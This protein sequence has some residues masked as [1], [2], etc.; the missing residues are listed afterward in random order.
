MEASYHPPNERE[1]IPSRRSLQPV[2]HGEIRSSGDVAVLPFRH[3]PPPRDIK[4]VHTVA[5]CTTKGRRSIVA[6]MERHTTAVPWL[7][8]ENKLDRI[9]FSALERVLHGI[10]KPSVPESDAIREKVWFDELSRIAKANPNPDFFGWVTWDGSMKLPHSDPSDL[11]P[12]N[13]ET[14]HSCKDLHRPKGPDQTH[15][16]QS[17][18]PF[19]A[20]SKASTHF[21]CYF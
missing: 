13:L 15:R 17:H 3:C 7:P 8:A 1:Q 18:L 20:C 11:W 2:P 19:Y 4:A 21:I 12:R 9:I 16:Y 14:T 6:L 10:D 5:P